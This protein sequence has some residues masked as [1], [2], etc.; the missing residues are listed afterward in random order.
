MNPQS[1]ALKTHMLTITP[2]MLFNCFYTRN[3]KDD[4][5]LQTTSSQLGYQENKSSSPDKKLTTQLFMKKIT[6]TG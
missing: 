5:K 2:P 3:R 1:T 4:G 6:I